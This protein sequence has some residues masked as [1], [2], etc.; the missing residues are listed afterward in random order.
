MS[1]SVPQPPGAQASHAGPITSEPASDVLLETLSAARQER[2][3]SVLDQY[4]IDV[5]EGRS[6]DIPALLRQHADIA[7]VLEHYLDGLQLVRELTLDSGDDLLAGIDAGSFSSSRR[8]RRRLPGR[9]SLAAARHP[10]AQLGPYA[11]GEVIGRGA[12]GIV[13]RGIDT[14][15]QQPVAVKVLAFS[16]AVDT[17]RIDRFRREAKTAAALDHPHVVPVYA[18]GCTAGVNYYAMQLVEGESL[19]RRLQRRLPRAS[20]G[21]THSA[22]P[23][24]VDTARDLSDTIAERAVAGAVWGPDGYR[25]IAQWC[26]AAAN[27]LHAAHEVGVIHRDVKPSN[28]LLGND[29]HLW[30][31]DF[32]LARVQSE[33]GL[34]Q[35]G[36]L[37]G[38]VRYMSPEQATGQAE[39]ID[40]RTDVYGLGAT[41]YEL[42][43]GVPAFPGDDMIDLLKRI[44]SCEPPTPREHDPD[45]P[46]CLETIIRRAMRPRPCDRYP[47]AAAMAEDLQRFAAGQPILAH[48]VT[49]T[50]RW[51]GWSL[52]HRRLAAGL[53]A[54]WTTILA[55]S[56]I[57]TGLL[58]QAQART[59][60]AWQ[61]SHKHYQQARQIVDNL[62]S[63]ARRLA[64]IPAADSVRQEI[65]T[66]T[67]E[68]YE[69]FIA[70]AARDPL[71]AHDV[72]QTRL[73][74]ARLTALSDGFAQADVAYQ[75]V[76]APY[77]LDAPMPSTPGQL[78]AAASAVSTAAPQEPVD[79][80]AEVL[81]CAQAL[82]EWGL[83]ASEH[84]HQELARQRFQ[85]A[86]SCLA[87]P[88]A[89]M[90]PQA[91][92][93]ITLAT[94]LTHNNLAVA[95]L[96]G[97]LPTAS[98]R[99]L[100]IAI[101]LLESLPGGALTRTELAGEVADAFSNL[102]ALLGEAQQFDA[103]VQAAQQSLE[104]RQ[105]AQPTQVVEYQSRLAITYNNLAAYHWKSG[106]NDEAISAYRQA[107]ELL[108]SAI[109]GAPNRNDTRHR[110]AVTLNNLGMALVSHQ[111]TSSSVDQATYR[112]SAERAFERAQALSQQALAADPAS[113]EALRRLAGIHNNYAVYLQQQHRASD[114]Q[115]QL[116]AARELLQT[117]ASHA[118]LNDRDHKLSEQIERNLALAQELPSQTP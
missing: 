3:V 88:A 79:S 21:T 71:L 22:A 112:N 50:E 26:A 39:L 94:A 49:R 62:S 70:D 42:A 45:L 25:R 108:E 110:L 20:R 13:Y 99:H 103:A 76:L 107:A 11:V 57:A 73:E 38:T 87:T 105:Q 117:L 32:G 43:T 40:A 67:I 90:T 106:R 89:D 86:L 46:R 113:A 37:V 72:A 69:Q 55:I 109:R 6:V 52:R 101:E 68:Y 78:T 8:A 98:G 17:S 74:I 2:L 66:E 1:R 28:L 116:L 9:Q 92:P 48:A 33:H 80:V 111:A 59:A 35:T 93:Q 97:A 36:E 63:V 51:I 53:F 115:K 75:S 65:L 4:L 54:V 83:L 102:S 56:L 18:V 60:A 29:G 104:I 91:Q 64:S 85:T 114:A 5:E 14:R 95:E 34:T 84:G 12:M 30:V 10:P 23:S 100:Q 31:T 19:D 7:D 118:P 16:S 44:Q 15:N 61:Q 47:T 81:L 24:T 41:L 27:A 96:R 58:F 82:N 77:G